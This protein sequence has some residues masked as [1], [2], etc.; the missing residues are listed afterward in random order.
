MSQ[1]DPALDALGSWISDGIVRGAGAAI[2]HRGEIVADRYAGEAR[3]GVPVDERT[4]FGLASVSKPL[5]AAAVVRC[6]ELGHFTLET[7]VAAVIPEFSV[8]DDPFDD[9]AVAQLE[10]L[11]HEIT[12]RQLLC[13]VSGLPENI[14]VRRIRMSDQPT[15]Q[16][17]TA[18]MI[19]LPLESAPG[20]ELRYSNAGFGIAAEMV[21]RAT[22]TPVH[23][24]LREEIL[25]PMGLDDVA[26]NPGE[27]LR[28]RL[29]HT[30][31]AAS[32]GTSHESYN[33]PYWQELGIP[34][35]GY[36]ATPVDVARFAGSFMAPGR[37]ALADDSCADM[38]VD[39]TGGI[40]GGVES[41]GVRWEQG[42]WGLGWEVAAD[43]TRHWTGTL[44]SPRTFCH[45]GQAGTL[46]WA[47][48]ERDLALAVFGNRTV[49]QPWPLR[50]PRWSRLSDEIV[51]IADQN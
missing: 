51:R 17:L 29:T 39:A 22:G 44:R 36:F 19:N 7:S 11:R 50:P 10:V 47:D 14:G 43:K 23:T 27:D 38:I 2:W 3:P 33:S 45:W 31:D 5:T 37:S 41:A 21:E 35:G 24:F 32:P 48:P 1:F 20:D 46:V 26:T 6:V 40:P 28:E 42:A 12:V 4:L 25:V 15:L 16:Q 8:I 49:R 18:A 30:D 13:H 34:W 9:D